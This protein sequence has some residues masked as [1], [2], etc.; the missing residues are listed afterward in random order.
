MNISNDQLRAEI[1]SGWRDMVRDKTMTQQQWD[2]IPATARKEVRDNSDLIPQ[3]IG[4]EGYR[5]E[6]TF[7][8]GSTRRL[9]VGIT[10]GWKPA[11]LF[12]R[13][14]NQ[15]GS[16][17]LGHDFGAVVSVRKIEQVR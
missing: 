16:S 1:V 3:L 17:T 10:S 9:I 5:C 12:L 4:C 15:R 13:N 8:D 11:H 14:R 7:T 6:I 2:A